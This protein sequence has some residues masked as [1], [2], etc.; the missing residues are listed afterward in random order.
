MMTMMSFQ[1]ETSVEGPLEGLLRRCLE[2]LRLQLDCSL[3]CFCRR[4][5]QSSR[6]TVLVLLPV[7]LLALV[8]W[9]VQV[10]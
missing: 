5:G 2:A 3:L 6:S 9:K 4:Y 10:D 1:L 8:P 7:R